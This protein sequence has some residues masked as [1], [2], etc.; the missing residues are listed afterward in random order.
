MKKLV[1]ILVFG[2][3]ST[4]ALAQCIQFEFKIARPGEVVDIVDI[5]DRHE[6]ETLVGKS[7]KHIVCAQMQTLPKESAG[8]G[9]VIAADE[10]G[11]FLVL[12]NDGALFVSDEPEKTVLFEV[13]YEDVLEL[14]LAGLG[15]FLIVVLETDRYLFQ[16]PSDR[17]ALA[18]EF[19]R[20]V[21][22]CER[23]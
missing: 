9:R 23:I 18:D 20:R 7:L 19:C 17:R 10:T 16:Y 13:R 11:G 4:P 3:F 21:R 15:R 14:Q 1:V 22:D 8:V 2:F 6:I 5:E 12:T